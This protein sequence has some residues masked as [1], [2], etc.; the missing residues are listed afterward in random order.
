MQNAAIDSLLDKTHSIY[1]LVIL[2]SRRAIEL[3]EGAQKLVDEPP[4]T[5][6]AQIALDEILQGKIEY[7][8]KGEK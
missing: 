2:A 5:K 7:K 3:A 1:K 6:P 8:I 4:D